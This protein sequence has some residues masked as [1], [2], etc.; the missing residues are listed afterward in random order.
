MLWATPVVEMNQTRGVPEYRKHMK[1][2]HR[3][4]R[5]PARLPLRA[6]P[7]LG[8]R[9]A[10]RITAH[11]GGTVSI[12]TPQGLRRVSRR[13]D[14][15][16]RQAELALAAMRDRGATLQH[17]GG[18]DWRLSNGQHVTATYLV[19]HPLYNGDFTDGHDLAVVF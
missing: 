6:Q 3:Q 8:R 14:R 9:S 4:F 1:L 19:V 11:E 2:S 18:N 5:H 13:L 17:F 7:L 10:A 12:P 16:R 15:Q